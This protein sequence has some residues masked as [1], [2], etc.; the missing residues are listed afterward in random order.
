MPT[1]AEL[2]APIR[3]RIERRERRLRT[4]EAQRAY[5]KAFDAA[6][7]RRDGDFGLWLDE[8]AKDLRLSGG[9]DHSG[10]ARKR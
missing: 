2:L 1:M 9:E 7:E 6:L 4:V 3:V 8:L 5:L 10:P